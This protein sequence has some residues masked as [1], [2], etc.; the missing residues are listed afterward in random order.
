MPTSP[1]IVSVLLPQPLP[2]PFDYELPEGMSAPLGTFVVVPLGP[3]EMIGVV[4]AERGV[5]SNRKLK[6]VLEVIEPAPPLTPAMR[7]FI[8]RAAKYVCSPAGNLL[9]MAMRSREALEAAPV[10]TLVVAT[11]DLPERMTPAREKA[12]A[13]AALPAASGAV[14]RA[15]GVSAGVVKGL[16]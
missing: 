16:V 8:E 13:A 2:E 11:G 9:A 12:L 10:E 6:P 14:A 15:A 1:R 7:T 3:R 4:W 5:P